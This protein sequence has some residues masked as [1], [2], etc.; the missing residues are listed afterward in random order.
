MK[1]LK[2]AFLGNDRYCGKSI[3]EGLTESVKEE[4]LRR[5]IPNKYK[6]NQAVFLQGNIPFGVYYLKAGKIKIVINNDD[7]KET[8]VR[9]VNPGEVFGHRALLAHENYNATAVILEDAEVDFFDKEFIFEMVKLHPIL[10]LN[11][12]SML[13]QAIGTIEN[14][15]SILVHKNVRERLARLLISLSDTYGEKK[16][17]R[18]FLNIKL[19]REDMASMIGTTHETLA[20]L[21]TEFKNE[22]IIFQDGKDIYIIN[23]KKL[24]E[25]AND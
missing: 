8:I 10:A 5:A 15:T 6:K 3:F 24:S 23:T 2:G 20:R 13:A 25:F 12:L 22:G 4:F 21:F 14:H 11:F 18:I 7:G 16:D 19:T 9:I 1:N 17:D